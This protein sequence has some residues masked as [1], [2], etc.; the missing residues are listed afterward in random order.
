MLKKN[1][2]IESVVIFTLSFITHNIYDWFPNFLTSIFFPVNESIWEHLKMI[3]STILMWNIIKFVFTNKKNFLFSNVLFSSLSTI[4][5]FLIIYLPVDNLLKE[6]NLLVT[7]IIYYISLVFG[8]YIK[9][10]ILKNITN[11]KQINLLSIII[12]FII[13]IIF[14]YLTYNPIDNYLFIDPTKKT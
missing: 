12:L 8:Y 14:G 11:E 13:I 4:I 2:I 6:H 7:L 5:I 10:I 3:F 1:I 9:T